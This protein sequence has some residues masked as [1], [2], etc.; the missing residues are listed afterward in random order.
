MS[1]L[2][3]GW[4][5]ARLEEIAQV[6]P[7][8]DKSEIDS[9]LEVSFVPMPAVEAESGKIDVSAKRRFSEVVKGYTGF[10]AKDI[11][12]AKITPCMEN[13]KMAVVPEVHG[14][15]GFGSTEFHVLRPAKGIVPKYLYFFVSSK[16]F[17]MNA[18]HNMTGAVGQRRVPTTYF[19]Q[20]DIPL[21]PSAEQL[22]IVAKLEELF[23]ELDAGVANLKKARAQLAVYRQALLKD[24][25]EGKL[26]AKWRASNPN[27]VES[28]G[29][30]LLRIKAD[31]R[32]R[33]EKTQLLKFKTSGKEPPSN[34]KTIYVDPVAPEA[35]ELPPL[36]QGW[37]A[38][39][40]DSLTSRIT[41]GSRDWLKY[42]GSGSGTFIM[43][44][45][46]RPG[47]FDMS[48]RQ[49][50]NPPAGD[51]SCE[52][53]MV[54]R[55]DLLVT[56]VGANTGDV[57]R[58][59]DE[60]SEHY[61]CQSVALMRPVESAT[62]RYLD[63]YFNSLGGGQLHFRRYLYGAGRPHLS[64]DQLKM[65]PVLLPPIAEQEVIVEV[66]ET[67]SSNIAALE[68][69][70]DLNLQKAEALRQSILKKAFAGELVPQD[71]ADESAAALPARIRAEREAQAAAAGVAKAGKPRKIKAP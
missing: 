34:W 71:P 70:I 57:C 12:F 21:P 38:A 60:L 69:D 44:Q 43:A 15:L 29:L 11:L 10:K 7:R 2:P 35:V 28:G 24:A 5:I 58:V 19:S 64:F 18:E 13:G 63:K 39:S 53:S 48:F 54:A 55:D 36:P 26:T 67:Q 65:T 1:K 9:D 52:R 8:L 40:M 68:A 22:R 42:Y 20:A 3:K 61:V 14:G 46:V 31:R 25:I 50:V 49:T 33:W 30:L 27:L 51:S 6:N 17:R 4:I 47:R 16:S 37:A 41:S 32:K 66:V 62:G 23:S 45:N 56:I 59:P